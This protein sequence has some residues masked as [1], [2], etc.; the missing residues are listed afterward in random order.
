M[1]GHQSR[2]TFGN[3]NRIRANLAVK[4][5]DNKIKK[6]KGAF[7]KEPVNDCLDIKAYCDPEYREQQ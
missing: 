2:L 3:T 7:V 5:Q 1:N 4:Q 6:V